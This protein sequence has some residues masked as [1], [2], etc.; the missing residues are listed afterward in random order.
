MARNRFEQVDEVQDDAITLTLGKH[1]DTA[2][3][4]VTIPAGLSQGQVSQNMTSGRV[5]AKDAYRN[6]IKLAN[7]MKSAIV[8]LDP[9]GLWEPEWGDLY[10]PVY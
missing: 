10:R 5:L 4:T 7:E 9:E 6:A 1:E 2:Y 3:G 8:V